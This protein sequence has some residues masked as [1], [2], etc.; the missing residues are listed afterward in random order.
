[1]KKPSRGFIIVAAVLPMIGAWVWFFSPGGLQWR[2]MRAVQSHIDHEL[3]RVRSDPRFAAVEWY[4]ATDERLWG[5]GEVPGIVE[6]EALRHAV[7]TTRPTFS[8]T[9]SIQY[10]TPNGPMQTSDRD[11]PEV[12]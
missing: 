9:F 8:V 2:R 7:R 10:Q 1:M 3:A 12:K 5:R 6:Y 11:D 4:A